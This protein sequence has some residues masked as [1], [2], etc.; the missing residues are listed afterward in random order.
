MSYKYQRS[1]LR[2]KVTY[3]AVVV[4]LFVI[5]TFV[6]G[7]VA[8]PLSGKIDEKFR[9]WSIAGQAERLDMTEKSQGEMEL[10][11]SAGRLLLTG[12]RGLMICGL[13]YT[14]IEMQKKH[15]WNQ[16]ELYVRLITKLQPHFIAPWMYQSWNLAYNVSVEMDN[17]GDMYFYIARGIGLLAEGESVNRYNP[18]MRHFIAFYYQNKFGVSDKV[19]TL[20]CLLELSCVA[21]RDRNVAEL[22]RGNQIQPEAFEEFCKQNPRLIRKLREMPIKYGKQEGRDQV[23]LLCRTPTDVVKF[24]SKHKTILDVVTR[25]RDDSHLFEPEHYLQQFPVLP[26]KFVG[27]QDELNPSSNMKEGYADAHLVARAWYS[28]ANEAVPPPNEEPGPAPLDYVDPE[29]KRRLPKQPMLIIFLQGPPRSAI[30]RGRMAS[31]GRLV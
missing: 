1:A 22:Q 29:R 13:W 9:Q 18:D 19:T 31:Q 12:S 20:R 26:Q 16:V 5:T 24:L 28:Y 17:L 23:M 8:M 25:F 6:R 15:E 4:A 7:L 14:A 11:G 27:G 10:T 21:P 2:R 3:F 30:L